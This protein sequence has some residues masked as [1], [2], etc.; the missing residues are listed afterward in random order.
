M[1]PNIKK[2]IDFSAEWGYNALSSG[3]FWTNRHGGTEAAQDIARYGRLKGVRIL[4]GVGAGGYHGFYVNGDNRFNLTNFLKLNPRLRAI[5]RQS[6]EPSDW[7]LCLYQPESI[8]WLREGARWLCR[9]FR[10]WRG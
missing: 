6:G 5:A 10:N 2:L 4:P 3:V 9:E 7:W 8:A 1:W